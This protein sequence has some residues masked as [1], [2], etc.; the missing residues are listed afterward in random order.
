MVSQNLFFIKFGDVFR[1]RSE[2][3]IDLLMGGVGLV[4][5]VWEGVCFVGLLSR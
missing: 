4:C 2:V 1:C 5:V 3:L